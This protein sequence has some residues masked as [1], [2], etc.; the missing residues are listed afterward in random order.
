ME[1]VIKSIYPNV[2]KLNNVDPFAFRYWYKDLEKKIIKNVDKVKI[3][4]KVASEK[5]N[6]DILDLRDQ[7]NKLIN[8]IHNANGMV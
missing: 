1:S 5:P 6:F 4:H 3:A 8:F 7:I 2:L